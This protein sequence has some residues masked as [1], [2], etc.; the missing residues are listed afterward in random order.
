MKGERRAGVEID[1]RLREPSN[2][3][4]FILFISDIF[5]IL[6]CARQSIFPILVIVHFSFEIFSSVAG[7]SIF[8]SI[9]IKI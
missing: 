2:K 7:I 4:V 3:F 5:A 1:P 6:L 8:E 9:L